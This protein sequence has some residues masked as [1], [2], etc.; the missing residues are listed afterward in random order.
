MTVP[1]PV[2]MTVAVPITSTTARI[3]THP[4]IEPGGPVSPRRVVGAPI[5]PLPVLD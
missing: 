3:E 4:R 5:P 2:I 1:V